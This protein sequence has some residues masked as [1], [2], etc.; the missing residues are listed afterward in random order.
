[1]NR[2]DEPQAR[3]PNEPTP[4][5]GNGDAEIPF[6][7]LSAYLDDPSDF[8]PDERARLDAYL[9]TPEGAARVAEVRLLANGLRDLPQVEPPRSFRLSPAQ[10]GAREPVVLRETPTWYARHGDKLRWATAAAALLFVLVVSADLLTHGI[11]PG[12]DDMDSAPASDLRQESQPVTGGGQS[13]A[14]STTSAAEAAEAE[15]TATSETMALTT[16]DATE[17]GQPPPQATPGTGEAATEPAGGDD[18]AQDPAPT[19]AGDGASTPA[20]DATPSPEGTTQSDM[21]FLT[22]T[23]ESEA[24]NDDDSERA[25]QVESDESRAGWRIAEFSIVVVLV[26]LLTLLAVLPRVASRRG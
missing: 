7:Q 16:E 20:G 5:A 24:V 15:A 13:E 12:S 21:A 3:R 25:A 8:G 11:T 2:D 4:P 19:I 14:T 6:A 23:E 9:T 1:M 26:M 22:E 10:V 17:E 18:A